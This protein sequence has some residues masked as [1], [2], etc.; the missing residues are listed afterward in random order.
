MIVQGRERTKNEKA[1]GHVPREN[2]RKATKRGTERQ[3]DTKVEAPTAEAQEG[4]RRGEPNGFKLHQTANCG[5]QA[6]YGRISPKL[7]WSAGHMFGTTICL[8]GSCQ[9]FDH[10]TICA[11][12]ILNRRRCTLWTDSICA[13]PTEEKKRSEETHGSWTSGE[14]WQHRCVTD[15]KRLLRKLKSL[16]LDS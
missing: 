14:E 9:R 11:H 2:E 5:P 16:P 8:I 3:H 15:A 10:I 4:R 7:L 13:L 12:S 6:E 1:K